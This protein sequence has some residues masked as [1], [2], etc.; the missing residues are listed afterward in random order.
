M[1]NRNKELADYV[2][3]K[4]LDRLKIIAKETLGKDRNKLLNPATS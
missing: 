1:D 4:I 2:I 3:K